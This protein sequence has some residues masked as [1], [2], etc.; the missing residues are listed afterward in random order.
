MNGQIAKQARTA[1]GKAVAAGNKKIEVNFPPVPNGTTDLAS[2]R[3]NFDDKHYVS[4]NYFLRMSY[5]FL[6]PGTTILMS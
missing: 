4:Q 2:T 1:V 3:V 6:L 5:P